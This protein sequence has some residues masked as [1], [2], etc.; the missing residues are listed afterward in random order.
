MATRRV[1]ILTSV[2]ACLSFAVPAPAAPRGGTPAAATPPAAAAVTL[3]AVPPDV[4]Q[5]G[6]ATTSGRNYVE[7][8]RRTWE[9]GAI[10]SRPGGSFAGQIGLSV[11]YV[12]AGTYAE[13]G[14]GPTLV[15]RA[16]A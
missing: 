12:E 9:L 8:R 7:L 6:L 3:L 11:T 13:S 5:Q 1:L 2:F 16:P 15:V 10:D 4:L 14:D